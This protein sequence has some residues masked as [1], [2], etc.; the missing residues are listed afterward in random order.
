M[1][2]YVPSKTTKSKDRV[3]EKSRKRKSPPKNEDDVDT[4]V[5]KTR[6]A[7]DITNTSGVRRSARN[8]GKTVDYKS[9]VVKTFPEAT[10]EAARIAMMSERKAASRDRQNPYV[11]LFISSL[12]CG[13]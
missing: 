6:A 4:K 3:P 9:E 5:V 12:P 10:S 8:A 7:Q 11:I 2:N 13:N 1:K